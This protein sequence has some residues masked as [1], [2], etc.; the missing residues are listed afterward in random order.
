MSLVLRVISIVII[1]ELVISILILSNALVTNQA[2]YTRN[3]TINH[4]GLITYWFRSKL[5][6]LSK[7]VQI[8]D[9]SKTTLACYEHFL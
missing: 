7:P 4:Y 6:C 9:N 5:V 1:S 8:I 2:F 3:L